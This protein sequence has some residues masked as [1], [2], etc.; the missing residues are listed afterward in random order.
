MAVQ[1]EKDTAVIMREVLSAAVN[2]QE[3]NPID[4]QNS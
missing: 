3:P 4:N 2:R 1:Q